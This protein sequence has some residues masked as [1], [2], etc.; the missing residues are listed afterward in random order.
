MSAVSITGDSV[1]TRNLIID[2][3]WFQESK[4]KIQGL[5]FEFQVL[6]LK[7]LKEISWRNNLFL[8]YLHVHARYK[9]VKELIINLK[10]TTWEGYDWGGFRLSMNDKL[11]KMVAPLNCLQHL[12]S[13]IK[14]FEGIFSNWTHLHMEIVSF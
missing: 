10:L 14:Q 6:S 4:I 12:T 11:K 13:I 5:S 9:D 8:E 3:Q 2:H 7:T 1:L